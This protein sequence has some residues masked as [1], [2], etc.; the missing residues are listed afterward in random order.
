MIYFILFLFFFAYHIKVLNC[1]F[2]LLFM[3]ENGKD[4]MQLSFNQT[5]TKRVTMIVLH[6]GQNK[7]FRL[8][9]VNLETKM[10][11]ARIVHVKLQFSLHRQ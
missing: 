4:Y 10:Q 9:S 5:C 6:H 3:R 7:C 8:N 1:T 11:Y 2:I